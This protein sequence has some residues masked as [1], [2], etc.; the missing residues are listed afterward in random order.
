MICV[1]VSIFLFKK[2]AFCLVAQLHLLVASTTLSASTAIHKYK[3]FYFS[4][5]CNFVYENW[6]L[7]IYVSVSASTTYIKS[8][9]RSSYTQFNVCVYI[10]TQSHASTKI[11]FHRLHTT[12][13]YNI[14]RTYFV[15]LQTWT[16]TNWIK[17]CELIF[18]MLAILLSSLYYPSYPLL[19][20]KMFNECGF[21][22]IA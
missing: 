10:Y 19:Q 8:V 3:I 1:S 12:F 2:F 18:L 14:N 22:Y 7:N 4:K 6:F 9:P 16:E 13:L 21:I 5:F 15:W 11:P 20:C 17:H